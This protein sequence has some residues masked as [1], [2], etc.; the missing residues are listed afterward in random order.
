M[1]IGW[2][3][4]L[5]A[6][7]P[8]HHFQPD[9]VHEPSEIVDPAFDWE[10]DHWFGL[11]IR[12]YIIYEL[13]VGTFTVEGTLDAI[14]PHLPELRDLGVTAIELMPI[15]QF[16]GARNWGYEGVY[17]FSVQNSYGGPIGLKRLV[18]A[19]HRMAWPSFSMPFITTLAPKATTWQSLAHFHGSLSDTLG[20]CAQLR[21][22]RQ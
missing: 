19:A 4:R 6:L 12:D 15:A 11:P 8:H 16:P 13:H 7:T 10:D 18:N 2:V 5:N 20:P 1:S 22:A 3:K 21:R 17:P 9:G 14:I